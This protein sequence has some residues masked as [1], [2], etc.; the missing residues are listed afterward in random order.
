MHWPSKLLWIDSI[1]GLTAGVFVLLLSP[2]L[3]DLYNIPLWT[4][5]IMGLA[6]V[7]YGIY[8]F[9][10]A[11][12]K[13]RS[14]IMIIALVVGNATWA[15]ICFAWFSTFFELASIWGLM[16]LFGEGLFVGFLASL[17]WRWRELLKTA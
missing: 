6:N 2:W 14:G 5:R 4:L 11:R 8:S 3:T 13:I 15:V 1:A 9:Q 12:R 17:E 7:A 16:H 10:L